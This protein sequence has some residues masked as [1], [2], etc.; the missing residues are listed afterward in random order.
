MSDSSEALSVAIAYF[1]SAFFLESI[2]GS[3]EAMLLEGPDKSGPAV[4]GR[5]PI[6]ALE[7]FC[8]ALYGPKGD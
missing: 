7:T 5:R 8:M 4:G 6:S 2:A 3:R 1:P